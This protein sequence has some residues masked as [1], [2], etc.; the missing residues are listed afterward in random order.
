VTTPVLALRPLDPA[1]L[2]TFLER[3]IAGYG[4][5]RA[6]AVDATEEAARAHARTQTRS[7]LPE[8]LA[9][10]GHHVYVL[11]E[12][13]DAVGHAWLALLDVDGF[14]CAYL[15]DLWLREDARGRGL[16]RAAMALVEG[17]ARGLGARDLELHVFAHNARARRLY[18][19]LGYRITSLMMRRSLR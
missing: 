11:V 15:Y 17:A 19:S 6:A 9:T 7:A 2:D 5:D 14:R 8:G 1:E 13:A 18:E 12:G 10:P 4:D 16:G 3:V